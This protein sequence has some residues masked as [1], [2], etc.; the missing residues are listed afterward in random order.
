MSR[1]AILFPGKIHDRVLE[2]LKDRFEIIAVAREE[3]LA[4]DS[5]TAGRIRGV[6]VSGSFPGSW[7]DQLPHAEVI[8]FFCGAFHVDAV[9]TDTEIGDHFS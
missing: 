8:A 9:I 2:R 1:I 7:M 5:E 6:A 4:L 3:K